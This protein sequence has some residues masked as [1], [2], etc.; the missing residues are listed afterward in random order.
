MGLSS[1]NFLVDSVQ[2]FYFGCSRSSKVIDFVNDQKRV[3]HFLLVRHSNLGP[4]LHSFRDI[5][6]YNAHDQPTHFTLVLGVFSFEQF[7]HVGVN[8]SRHLELFAV[9]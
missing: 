5:A 6:V 9:K 1:F 7:A 8:L 4:I 3:C 2:L